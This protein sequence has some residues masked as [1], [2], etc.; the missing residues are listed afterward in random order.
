MET[1]QR[2]SYALYTTEAFRKGVFSRYLVPTSGLLYSLVGVGLT[3]L[4]S[5][6]IL[7][8]LLFRVVYF[9]DVTA[10]SHFRM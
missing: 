3:V 2:L 10:A 4:S 1:L 7:S 8:P 6:K 5:L 9:S